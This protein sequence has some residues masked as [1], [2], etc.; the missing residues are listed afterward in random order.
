MNYD[1]TSA[2]ERANAN[3]LRR[4]AYAKSAPKY[5]KQIGF[6]ERRLFGT[7][8]RPWACSRA[9][10]RTLEV[11]VG[12]GLNLP[13][14]PGDA[15]LVGLDLSPEMLALAVDRANELGR[16]VNFKE[17]DAQELS[18]Q[19]AAFDTV[20][21][22]FSLC[23]IPDVERTVAEMKRVL[24][25]GGRL[26]LVDHIAS[27]VKP[28]YWLQRFIEFF[29]KRTEGEYQTRRPMIQVQ[30]AGFVVQEHERLRAGVIERLVAWKPIS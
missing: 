6:C 12:T 13:H 26:I 18:F 11:A 29:S 17:G 1:D 14:Y 15:E 10:G 21:C 24:R 19:D 2:E 23:G 9:I 22:T 8:H 28:I 16:R 5:D 4:R 30:E 20:V 7:D 3:E 25:P 27:S